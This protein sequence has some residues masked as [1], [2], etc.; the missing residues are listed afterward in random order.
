MYFDISRHHCF[1]AERRQIL[2][3]KWLETATGTLLGL[4]CY[5]MNNYIMR[6]ILLLVSCYWVWTIWTQPSLFL[7]RY[8]LGWDDVWI[9]KKNTPYLA[10]KGEPWDVLYKY[11]FSENRPRYNGSAQ[12]TQIDSK[13][14]S[15]YGEIK[16]KEE[17][18]LQPTYQWF[19]LAQ[20]TKTN[21]RFNMSRILISHVSLYKVINN[22]DLVTQFLAKPIIAV[23][24]KK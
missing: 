17:M 1:L 5:G 7:S 9:H 23:D 4:S 3:L 14:T 22:H 12:Y 19:S 13:V 24:H 15:R 10:I 20:P 6:L 2:P 16:K 11:F 21:T 8:S 18:D